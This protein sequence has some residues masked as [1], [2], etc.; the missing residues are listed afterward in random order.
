M[1]KIARRNFLR[2]SAVSP[3]IL[4]HAAALEET[5]PLTRT[6]R[7]AEGPFY[8]KGDRSNDSENL[9]ADMSAPRGKTLRFRGRVVNTQA[10]AIGGL[11]VDMWQADPMGRYKHPY[12]SSPGERLDDF[13]YWGKAE[14][15]AQGDFSFMTYI[16]GGYGGRPA[17]LHYIVWKDSKRL[18]TSQ[19]YFR[20]LK[21]GSGAAIKSERHILRKAE[22]VRADATDY[23]ID[24][25]IVI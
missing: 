12:D 6:P 8:P 5:L 10:E 19:V 24:F 16:P 1:S 17:H 18:L 7:D 22:L 14:T 21:Q 9:L 20:G 4:G 3:L 25:R 15:N 11:L 13:A 2:L 23:A